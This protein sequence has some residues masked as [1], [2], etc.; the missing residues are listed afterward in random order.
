M[1]GPTFTTVMCIFQLVD[2]SDSGAVISF[3]WV[4][5]SFASE[6]DVQVSNLEYE[7]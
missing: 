3:Q 6:I 1:S 2:Q 5:Y 4:D 7:P